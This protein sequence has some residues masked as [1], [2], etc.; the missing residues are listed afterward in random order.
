MNMLVPLVILFL[1]AGTES[2]H[3]QEWLNPQ[4]VNENGYYSTDPLF[5]LWT[6]DAERTSYESQY[7]PY[8][9]EDFFRDSPD[10]YEH[11]QEAIA[12]QRQRFESPFYPYFGDSFLGWAEKYPAA[13]PAQGDTQ[14]TII[15]QGM[16]GYRSIPA[17]GLDRH[18]GNGRRSARWKVQF[19]CRRKS[20]PRY[21]GL[22]WSVQLSEE[23]FFPRGV[24]KIVYL[25]PGTAVYV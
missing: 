25:E 4:H 9:G 5:Y 18:R 22:R 2:V 7:Y 6:S 13:G 8:F 21:Q 12:A 17:W 3:G 1:I 23:M 11:S 19:R 10:P 20:E 16:G 14:V 24:Q 15:S